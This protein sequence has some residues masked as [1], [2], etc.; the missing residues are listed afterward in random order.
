MRNLTLEIELSV[1]SSFLDCEKYNDTK[2][3]Y[4]NEEVFISD[5]NKTIANKINDHVAKNKSLT[6]FKA[7]LIDFASSKPKIQQ[8][9]L[10]IISTTP[11][12]MGVAKKY[13]EDLKLQLIERKLKA[14]L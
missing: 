7:K 6:L 4:L 3:F 8:N 13:Y 14:K 5:F 10:N 11:L 12:P 9:V 2:Y 1:L